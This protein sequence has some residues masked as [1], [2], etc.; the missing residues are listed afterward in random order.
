MKDLGLIKMNCG[1]KCMASQLLRIK[2][3]ALDGKGLISTRMHHLMKTIMKLKVKN[4]LLILF[5][6]LI[7]VL[8][9]LSN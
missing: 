3:R 4:L 8:L 1:D 6:Y 9:D 5:C 2:I 7:T